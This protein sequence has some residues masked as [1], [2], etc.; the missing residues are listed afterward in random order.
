MGELSKADVEALLARVDGPVEEVREAV[1]DALAIVLGAPA[2]WPE[3]VRLAAARAGWPGDRR[4]ALLAGDEDAL[5]DLV[6]EL[7]EVRGLDGVATDGLGQR[8]R[9]VVSAIERAI[10]AIASADA[11]KVR[12][13][14]RSVA[15]LDA[16]GRY[17]ALP[18][19]LERVAAELDAGGATAA[20]L[21]EVVAALGPGPLATEVERLRR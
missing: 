20:A 18:A 5:Y 21:D 15:E 8:Q 4:D 3:L 16:A 7:N 6:A 12:R 17:L 9:E 14:A 10:G 2:P 13:A 1:A 19:A 11:A